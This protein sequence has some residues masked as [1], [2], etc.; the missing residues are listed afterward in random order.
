MNANM[1]TLRQKVSATAQTAA[2][3]PNA[4]LVSGLVLGIIVRIL[5]Q[6]NLLRPIGYGDQGGNPLTKISPGTYILILVWLRSVFTKPKSQS[7]QFGF[8]IATLAAVV[9]SGVVLAIVTGQS[10]AIGYLFDSYLV[11]IIGLHLL[12]KLDDRGRN[13]VMDAFIWTLAANSVMLFAEYA[14]KTRFIPAPLEAA[15]GHIFRPAALLNHPLTSGLFYATAVP[16]VMLWRKP[17]IIRLAFALLFTVCVFAS[18]ARVASVLA[19]AAFLSSFGIALSRERPT[20]TVGQTWVLSQAL[21]IAGIVPIVVMVGMATGLG[22]RLA[23]GFADKS[24]NTRVWQMGML[25][26]LDAHQMMVGVGNL[27]AADWSFRLFQTKSV[28]SSIVMGVFMYGLPFTVLY[29]ALVFLALFSIAW[30]GDMLIKI[31]LAVFAVGSMTNNTLGTKNPAIFYAL[32]FAAAALT[33]CVRTKTQ[34]AP[35]GS[36]RRRDEWRRLRSGSAT[37]TNR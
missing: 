3:D 36:V 15:N 19:G 18:G 20:T 30:R 1:Q 28:E 29:H 37:W 26:Y 21:I 23:L 9:V 32:M 24:A 6:A 8:A 33:N 4:W 17:L 11:T 2:K 22:E 10:V 13:V 35:P 31:S 5:G 7:L 14:L 27:T 12:G 16:L 34:L 25:Q